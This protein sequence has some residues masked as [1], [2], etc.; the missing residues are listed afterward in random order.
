MKRKVKEGVGRRG[1]RG[2]SGWRDGEKVDCCGG[3][4]GRCWKSTGKKEVEREVG[5][6]GGTSFKAEGRGRGKRVGGGSRRLH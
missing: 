2:E 3:G 6:E 4:G 5:M 1:R